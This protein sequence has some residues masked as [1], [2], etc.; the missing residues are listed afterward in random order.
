[1]KTKV[2]VK[3]SCKLREFLQRLFRLEV[4][5]MVFEPFLDLLNLI[6]RKFAVV[7]PQSREEPP[8]LL[9]KSEGR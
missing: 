5:W 7:H 2:K 9:V 8:P 6:N 3:V 4:F 1:M